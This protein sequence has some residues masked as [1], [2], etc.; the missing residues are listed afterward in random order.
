MNEYD[1]GILVLKNGEVRADRFEKL[2]MLVCPVLGVKY[3]PLEPNEFFMWINNRVKLTN[4]GVMRLAEL[5]KLLGRG[6]KKSIETILSL[7]DEELSALLA[8]IHGG[9]SL[10]E[11]FRISKRHGNL[12]IF[13]TQ[14]QASQN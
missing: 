1:A 7:S 11:G 6:Q 2:V 12:Y 13:K 3:Y 14:N 4:F 5:N 10:P 9:T 8:H